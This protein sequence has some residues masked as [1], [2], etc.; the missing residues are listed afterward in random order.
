MSSR[1]VKS[2]GCALHIT[3]GAAFFV[4]S[5]RGNSLISLEG[6]TYYHKRNE[7]DKNQKKQRWVCSTHFCRGCRAVLYT[8]DDVIVTA[9]KDHNHE[10]AFNNQRIPL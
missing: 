2:D 6:Y 10:P 3:I 8:I 5:Q 4:M 7:R 9:K 1:S